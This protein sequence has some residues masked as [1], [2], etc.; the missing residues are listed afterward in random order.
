[1]QEWGLGIKDLTYVLVFVPVHDK[2]LLL[3]FSI[4]I[5]SRSLVYVHIVLFLYVCSWAFLAPPLS[6][7]FSVTDHTRARAYACTRQWELARA[8]YHSVLMHK[9]GTEEAVQ[10]MADIANTV[11]VL[12]MLSDNLIENESN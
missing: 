4:I 7:L 8:D 11:I 2:A 9:P 1:M 10:G 6:F 12:P 5:F 3:R